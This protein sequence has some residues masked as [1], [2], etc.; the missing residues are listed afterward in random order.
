MAAGKRVRRPPS[1][2][3]PAW[4]TARPSFPAGGG[5]AIS[6]S[7]PARAT[8]WPS[9][10]SRGA[11]LGQGRVP[12]AQ[13]VYF[14]SAYSVQHGLHRRADHHRGR[15]PPEVTDHLVVSV[16]GPKSDFQFRSLLRPRRGPHAA[17]G[18]GS[19]Q[20]GNHHRWS[21][22][23]EMRVAFF[24]PLPPARS[25]IADYSEA[26]LR[27]RSASCA[28]LEVFAGAGPALRSRAL[29]YRAVPGG[30]QRLP[31]F[32]VRGGS[33]PSGRGGDARIESAPPD[34]GSHHPARRL[35]RLRARVRVQRRPAGARLRR[36]RAQARG[37]AGLRRRADDAA[38]AGARARRG[39]AQPLHG[40]RN[41]RRRL[42]GPGRR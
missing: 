18:Q 26:L 20:R 21:W 37:G 40:G 1:I 28:E 25:G 39:R 6:A 10:I 31:R 35:G 11:E 32:R 27:V 33:A 22:C 30:Q 29:R 15:K 5:R 9:S 42:H 16:T 8:P 2:R 14:G 19:L 34:R 12:P 3:P 17:A 41:A 23:A 7:A 38:A 13:Q 36:A 24:S 4:R